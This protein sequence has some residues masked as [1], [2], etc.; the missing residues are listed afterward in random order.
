MKAWDDEFEFSTY[1]GNVRVVKCIENYWH[2][3]KEKEQEIYIATN[4]LDHSI[5]MIIK[6]MHLRWNIENCG[7]KS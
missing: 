7:F 3:G 2:E 4:M 6:I 5:R 1:D